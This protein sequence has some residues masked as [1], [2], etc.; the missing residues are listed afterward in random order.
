MSRLIIEICPHEPRA[1]ACLDTGESY[2][3]DETIAADMRDCNTSGNCQPACEYVRDV[4]KPDF[5]IMAR[6]PETGE[7]ENR[8]ATAKEKA[9]TCRAIYFESETD[10]DDELTAE[11]YLIWEAASESE[12]EEEDDPA[13]IAAS[14][15]SHAALIE[16][17]RNSEDNDVA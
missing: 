14:N 10:F 9:A 5:R 3:S 6:N 16:A 17:A 12:P 7:Y 1:S 11:T 15:L 2:W 8:P 4:L 13:V